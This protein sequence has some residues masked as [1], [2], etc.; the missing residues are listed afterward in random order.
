MATKL[1][2]HALLTPTLLPERTSE[3][4]LLLSIASPDIALQFLQGDGKQWTTDIEGLR[5]YIDLL[6]NAKKYSDLRDVCQYEID[7]G[8]DDWKVVKGWVDGSIGL[9][10]SGAE[11]SYF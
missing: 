2:N 1:V 11:N 9:L 8:A 3:A 10:E 4:L 6:H 5:I 7:Q